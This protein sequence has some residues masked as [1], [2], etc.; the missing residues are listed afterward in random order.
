VSIDGTNFTF[1]FNKSGST[2]GQG[3]FGVDDDKYY[4]GGMLMQA[5]KDDKYS[6]IKTVKDADGYTEITMLTTEEFLDVVN[7]TSVIPSGKSDDYDEYYDVEDAAKDTTVDGVETQY[8]LVNTSGTVQKGKSKAKDGD[9]RC[10][11]VKSNKEI[12]RVFVES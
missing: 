5:D 10:Y 1:L 6:V 9:D 8:R 3:K 12:K 7:A 11:E 2:K 4:L